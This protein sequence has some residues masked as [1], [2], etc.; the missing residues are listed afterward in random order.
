M[1][2]RGAS[3]VSRG[4]IVKIEVV[5]V[6]VVKVE[7]ERLLERCGRC[8]LHGFPCTVAQG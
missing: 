4:E 7:V 5:K 1:F 3:V 6:E 8:T 2:R